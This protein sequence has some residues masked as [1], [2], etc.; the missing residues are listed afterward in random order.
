MLVPYSGTLSLW[1]SL[2][3][4][5]LAACSNLWVVLCFILGSWV[6]FWLVGILGVFYHLHGSSAFLY[7]IGVCGLVGF[8]WFLP[9]SLGLGSSFCSP[10]CVRF[11]IVLYFRQSTLFGWSSGSSRL[12]SV[13]FCAAWPSGHCFS[14][15]PCLA[16]WLV[17]LSSSV[18]GVDIVF[19]VSVK[20]WSCLLW[21]LGLID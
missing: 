15:S 16:E 6:T 18:Q 11:D 8:P 12:L 10:I 3:S 9:S 4:V 19:H 2:A 21:V 14:T 20:S 1:S 13:G 5:W 7:C 17:W